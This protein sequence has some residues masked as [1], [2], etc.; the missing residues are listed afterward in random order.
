MTVRIIIGDNRKT[1]KTLLDKSVQS[2]ITSP[3]YW[4]L[5]DYG[6]AEW[7]GGDPEC[8]HVSHQIRTGMGLAALGEKYRG[9]G[10]K[11]GHVDEIQ[12]ADVCKKCGAVREDAQLGLEPLHDCL[13]WARG[14]EPCGR[15]YVC[16]LRSL[17]KELHRVL[18]DDGTFWLNLGD[19]Y[20]SSNSKQV[21]QTKDIGTSRESGVGVRPPR[22]NDLKPKDLVGIPWRVALALQADGWWLRSAP[23][24]IKRNGMPE[25]VTD[26]PNT[27]HE[28]WFL[29]S[30]SE[31]YFYD[32][33]AVREAQKPESIERLSR[34][35]GELHKNVNGA[36]GQTPQGLAQPRKNKNISKANTFKKTGSKREQALPFQSVGTHKPDR[37]EADH[38]NSGRNRRTSDWYFE[39]LDATIKQQQAYLSHL[40]HVRENGGLLLSDDG[41][42]LAF[43]VST[44]SFKD[45]HF[46]VFPPDLVEPIIKAS[47]SE[48][49][50]CSTCG[51]PWKRV[52]VKGEPEAT[53]ENPNEVRPYTAD[54]F[55]ET[56]GA[57][58]TTT[59]HKTRT[60]ETV[61]WQPTCG[62][63]EHEPVPCVILD[64][65]G[66][67]GTS[68]LV[69]DRLGRDA[70]LLELNEEYGLMSEKR[71]KD[72]AGMFADVTLISDLDLARGV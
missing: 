40:E 27:A 57:N 54:G 16:N 21:P 50:R 65:F 1:L 64:P 66:G 15:C 43:D 18:R 7:I 55:W 28:Y 51:A 42:P 58:D 56:N 9:G 53:K 3:P 5:R 20:Q 33:V 26:R 48:H 62:C 13:A 23:P 31:Q 11:Q 35:T 70:I 4:G 19:S 8:D 10:H 32:H 24:W 25:S 44:K 71:I 17:A 22:V 47:T 52:I 45:A 63:P 69:A 72:D 49:G 38:G 29:L 6:T 37:E 2:L 36:P 60:I 14:E 39:S 41:T 34:G 12:F 59:L 30:K 46:A 61:Y 68:G 67:A